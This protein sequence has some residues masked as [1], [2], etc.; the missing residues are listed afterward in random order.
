MMSLSLTPSSVQRNIPAL[1]R[2]L[3]DVQQKPVT[4]PTVRSPPTSSTSLAPLRPSRSSPWFLPRICE[5]LGLL[6]GI[7]GYISI[8][9]PP[10]LNERRSSSWL[11]SPNSSGTAKPSPPTAACGTA[12]PRRSGRTP[13]C[14]RSPGSM[15][16]PS[17]RRRPMPSS[18]AVKTASTLSSPAIGRPPSTRRTTKSGRWRK[19]PP[20]STPERV[21]R[22]TTR[23]R[24]RG[25][26]T[27]VEVPG[28]SKRPPS[29]RAFQPIQRR[30]E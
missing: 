30:S 29:L 9:T 12:S 8:S 15:R 24:K 22:P 2:S 19:W 3:P 17:T 13:P 7:L 26:P 18:A 21:F 16:S 1:F 5:I 10:P 20:T 6:S 28:R 11:T 25:T 23:T 4:A 27:E 14:G